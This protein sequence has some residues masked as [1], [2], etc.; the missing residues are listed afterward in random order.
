MRI[1]LSL[2]AVLVTLLAGCSSPGAPAHTP[3]AP[4][5]GASSPAPTPL[6]AAPTPA[7]PIVHTECTSPSEAPAPAPRATADLPTAPRTTVAIVGTVC[8][9]ATG[10]PLAGIAVSAETTAAFCAQGHQ[11]WRCGFS[12]VSDRQGHY[13]LTLFDVDTYNVTVEEDGYRAGGGLLRIA[14]QGVTRADWMLTPLG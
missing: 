8:S 13:A 14:H 9:S 5:A 7:A 6:P 10:E 3:P 2:A 11:P 1:P 12:T 4:L